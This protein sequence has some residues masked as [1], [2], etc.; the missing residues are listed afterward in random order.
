MDYDNL[1]RGVTIKD[2]MTPGYE[3]E[4]VRVNEDGSVTGKPFKEVFIY[5]END[6]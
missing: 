3:D 4:Y 2:L 5:E 1:M 6:E